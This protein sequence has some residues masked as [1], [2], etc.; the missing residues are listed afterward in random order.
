MKKSNNTIIL[1]MPKFAYKVDKESGEK[2]MEKVMAE[3][4]VPTN[5]LDFG[6]F[7]DSV[8]YHIYRYGEKVLHGKYWS[9]YVKEPAK[10]DKDK[11]LK[12]KKEYETYSEMY[13][14]WLAGLADKYAN[15]TNAQEVFLS[16]EFAKIFAIWVLGEKSYIVPAELNGKQDT[17]TVHFHFPDESKVSGYVRDF[18][19]GV[20]DKQKKTT[21][22]AVNTYCNTYFKTVGTAEN[23]DVYKNVTF[24]ISQ[25]LLNDELFSRSK[26]ALKADKKGRGIR[27]EWLTPFELTS[28]LFAICMYTLGMPFFDGKT[29]VEYVEE[30]RTSE[31]VVKAPARKT[32]KEEKK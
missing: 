27:N 13:V 3:I 7:Q 2:T 31:R 25:K 14:S 16:D 26:K 15:A 32:K 5:V 18:L 21:T 11:V 19:E 29:T 1:T 10:R 8:Q 28:Q 4:Y 30:L 17:E 23:D 22:E 9:E 24:K 12:L 6:T 20:T